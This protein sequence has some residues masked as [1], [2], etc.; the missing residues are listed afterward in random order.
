MLNVLLLTIFYLKIKPTLFIVGSLVI[1]INMIHVYYI[2]AKHL[3]L[4]HLHTKTISTRPILYFLV[5]VNASKN[6]A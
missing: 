1:N 6:I 3:R 4:A 5:L 2:M